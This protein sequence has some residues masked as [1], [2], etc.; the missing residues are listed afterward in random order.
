MRVSEAAPFKLAVLHLYQFSRWDV[1]AEGRFVPGGWVSTA[2][3]G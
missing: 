3:G 1:F 2:L